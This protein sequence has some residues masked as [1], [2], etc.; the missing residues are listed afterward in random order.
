MLSTL[1]LAAGLTRTVPILGAATVAL[2]W[3]EPLLATPVIIA[4]IAKARHGRDRRSR[5]DLVAGW[6]RTLAGELRAGRSLRAAMTGAVSAVPELRLRGIARLAATGRPMDE[7][8]ALLAAH[9]GLKPAAAA[10]RVAARTGG[11]VAAV[12]DALTGEAVDEAAAEREQRTLTVQARLSVTLV[13]GFPLAVL[14]YQVL[15]GAAARILAAGPIGVAIVL[16]GTGLLAVGLL[17]VWFMLRRARR[18][19]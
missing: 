17:A 16:L 15:S 3:S 9:E 19:T 5:H 6:L 2:V 11:S 8:A 10:L 4:G 1:L 12:F 18:P 13:A 14:A 7:A